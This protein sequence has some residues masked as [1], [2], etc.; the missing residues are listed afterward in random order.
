MSYSIDFTLFDEGVSK[1]FVIHIV[2]TEKTSVVSRYGFGRNVNW[3]AS[4]NL[5]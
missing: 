1:K 5:S 4:Q 2:P 3:Y